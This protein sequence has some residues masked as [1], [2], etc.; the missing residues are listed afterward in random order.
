VGN[1][2]FLPL[3]VSAA[4]LTGRNSWM[5][6]S[7]AATQTGGPS[8]G[9]LLVQLLRAPTALIV[10]GVSYLMSAVLLVSLP[11]P[12]QPRPGPGHVSMASLIKDGCRYVLRHPVIGPCTLCVTIG[13]FVAGGLLALTPVFLVRTLGAPAW[14][15]GV[16]IATEG[17]GSL[18]GASLASRLAGWVGTAR[19]VVVAEIASAVLALLMPSARGTWGFAVFGIGNAGLAA[20]V[21]VASILT[22][23]Y[24]QTASPP[25]L[26]PRVMATVRFISWG[27]I[28]LGAL[29]TGAVAT[30]AGNRTALWLA[31]L[32]NFAAPASLLASRIRRCRDLTE[33]SP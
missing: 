22:R 1:A 3:M 4:E 28:P 20:G 30:V 27:V 8:L 7:V 6:G 5:S 11:R 10:D 25:A 23:T 15:V 16:L 14:L 32:L 31:C 24:R 18:I 13:N 21:V 17:A 9:G 12:E 33:G 2:T 26:Y 29:A 19:A